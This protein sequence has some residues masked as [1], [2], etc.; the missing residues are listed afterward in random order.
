MKL[1]FRRRNV[2]ESKLLRYRYTPGGHQIEKRRYGDR[3]VHVSPP[4]KKPKYRFETIWHAMIGPRVLHGRTREEVDQKIWR[5]I[6]AESV[7]AEEEAK[8][9]RRDRA[10][11]WK[12]HSSNRLKIQRPRRG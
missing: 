1:R 8:R 10:K 2:P 12:R 3:I 7:R 5:F 9:R 6:S 11:G 4:S